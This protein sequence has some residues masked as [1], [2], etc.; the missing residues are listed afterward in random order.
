MR[1]GEAQESSADS[2]SEDTE[3]SSC[4]EQHYGRT[5]N[6]R[7]EIAHC[8][9]SNEDKYREQFVCDT[10]IV[11]GN[12]EAFSTRFSGYCRGMRNVSKNCT[13]A[14]RKQQSRFIVVFNGQENQQAADK[15]HNNMSIAKT[16]NTLQEFFKIR[17]L[18]E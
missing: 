6:Q 12:Q 2:G 18:Y 7:S 17:V 15:P 10:C 3:L 8:A 11:Q 13:E 5:A 4:C 14:N 16:K 9:D 1:E